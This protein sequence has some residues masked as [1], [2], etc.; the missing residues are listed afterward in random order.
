MTSTAVIA[1]LGPGFCEEFA[2]NLAREGHPV[3]LFARSGDYLEGFAAELREAGHEAHAVPT[4]LT[5]PAAVTEGVAEVREELGPVEVLAH[6]ASA[7]TSA[8]D[9]QLDPDRVEEMWRLY[10]HAGLLCFR[11]VVED[12][13][14]QGGTALFFG[15][16]PRGG[17]VAFK[18][19]KD[20]TRGLA[21]ALAD[22]YGARGVHV[23][24]VVID[25][26]MLNPDVRESLDEVDESEYIDPAAAAETCYHLVDQPARAR[27]FEL[28]LHATER[29]VTH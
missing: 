6:T 10:A 24:H 2:W 14:A 19:G 28:D 21:R 8:P 29:T 4:D 7:A 3:G 12:L 17:D 25:G 20:A 22:E 5:D 26:I 9:D 23:A 16:S 13:Q 27:T 15:A 11:E 1:G 18:S